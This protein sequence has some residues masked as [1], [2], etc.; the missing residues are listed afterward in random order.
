MPKHIWVDKCKKKYI[1]DLYNSVR[2]QAIG[3]NWE[4][5]GL[6]ALLDLT[7]ERGEGS[8][9]LRTQ[10]N[11]RAG[12]ASPSA[13]QWQWTHAGIVEKCKIGGSVHYRIRSEFYEAIGQVF[14]VRS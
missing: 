11:K 7:R 14:G 6:M 9:I 8:P 12:I 3:K 1:Q 10:I 2:K 5:R 4:E 13:G